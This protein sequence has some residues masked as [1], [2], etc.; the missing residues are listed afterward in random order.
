MVGPGLRIRQRRTE[1]NGLIALRRVFLS[2]V[3]TPLLLLGA[4]SFTEPWDSGDKRW[5][6]WAV[7]AM[8]SCTLAAVAWTRRRPLATAS[9]RE[10]GG[11]YRA[12]LFNTIIR[13]K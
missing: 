7:A 13:G 10:L 6:P 1:A 5:I 11:S 3:A 12:I 4:F 8:G 9:L 2:M